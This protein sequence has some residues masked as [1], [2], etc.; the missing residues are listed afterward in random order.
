[1]PKYFGHNRPYKYR[2]ATAPLRP[3]TRYPSPVPFRGTPTKN[4]SARLPGAGAPR[5]SNI[6]D[7]RTGQLMPYRPG[8]SLP[9]YKPG[10][11]PYPSELNAAARMAAR[12]LGLAVRNINPALRLAGVA[13]DI[14]EGLDEPFYKFGP[15]K[16]PTL[17]YEF[18]GW[19]MFQQCTYTGD[20]EVGEMGIDVARTCARINTTV[21]KAPLPTATAFSL[22]ADYKYWSGL[23]CRQNSITNRA[24]YFRYRK[25]A[26]STL[27]PPT[28]LPMA[29][30]AP[31]GIIPLSVP[32]PA[33]I[34]ENFPGRDPSPYERPL[35]PYAIPSIDI[36]VAPGNSGHLPPRPGIHVRR[37]PRP[38]ER[39]KK[40][41]IPYPKVLGAIAAL[42]DST[43]EA[44][45]I[46]DILYDNLG[47]K[48]RGAKSMNDKA[49][50]V[51]S[52]LATLD[53]DQAISDL[54]VNH[55]EDKAYG[56]FFSYGKHAPFGTNLTGGKPYYSIDVP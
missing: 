13:Y 50:C 46:V 4:L 47:K 51:Y 43:T 42:Y 39:E 22:T 25:I 3:P 32:M 52:N 35:P 49:Y 16:E 6:L 56:K 14:Y 17:P 37:K 48:C 8:S 53:I 1:M 26:G 2:T 11:S 20:C 21:P 55:Y 40:R 41:G 29:V 44:K 7:G 18:P 38:N 28:E 12:R 34:T 33:S 27:P 19:E 30:K 31:V 15:D 9:G 23:N 54:I 24:V 10:G 45:D 5:L 36:E